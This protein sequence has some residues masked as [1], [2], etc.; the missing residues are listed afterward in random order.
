VRGNFDLGKWPLD[1]RE[2]C[3]IFFV[4]QSEIA[5]QMTLPRK[6]VGCLTDF[7]ILNY[8]SDDNQPS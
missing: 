4:V 6:L 2:P 5:V 7:K 3:S 8:V 1:L